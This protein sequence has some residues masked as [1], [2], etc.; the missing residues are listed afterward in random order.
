MW[1]ASVSF[2][3]NP[4]TFNTCYC[5]TIVQVTGNIGRDPEKKNTEWEK[6]T[7]DCIRCRNDRTHH[8][9]LSQ[10]C[11]VTRV[12][13][14]MVR[15][16]NLQNMPIVWYN[17]QGHTRKNPQNPKLLPEWH[18]EF[19]LKSYSWRRSFSILTFIGFSSTD[20]AGPLQSTGCVRKGHEPGI[21]PLQRGDFV[22]NFER[23]FRGRQRHWEDNSC[24]K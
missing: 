7:C 13:R 8:L 2:I 24:N 23:Q 16:I 15:P 21:E 17:V 11:C 22:S 6:K 20:Q 12:S 5:P 1:R 3:A 18:T 4:P 10:E 19:K 9:F 14:D